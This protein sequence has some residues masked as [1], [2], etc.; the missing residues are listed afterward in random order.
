MT[1]LG[2][3]YLGVSLTLVVLGVLWASTTLQSNSAWVEV[4]VSVP[5]ANLLAPLKNVRYHVNLAG[6]MAGWLVAASLIAFAAI[7]AP[8]R[9]RVVARTRRRI[10]ELEREVLDLRRLPLR[11]QEEDE[12]LAAEAQLEDGTRKVMT[13][14]FAREDVQ[15]ARRDRADGGPR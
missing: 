12:L 15:A 5:R 4:V 10:K 6:L 3:V 8:F 7:R 1:A 13:E 14:T 11:Q 2:K 9:I